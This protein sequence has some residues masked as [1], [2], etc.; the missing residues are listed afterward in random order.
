MKSPVAT[1]KILRDADHEPDRRARTRVVEWQFGLNRETAYLLGGLGLLRTPSAAASYL[2]PSFGGNAATTTRSKNP[3][4]QHN[5][6][7]VQMAAN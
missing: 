5:D 3:S 4:P 7:A 6:F 2:A 1:G